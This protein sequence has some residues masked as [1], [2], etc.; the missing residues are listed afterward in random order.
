M[1]KLQ[2][3]PTDFNVNVDMCV[4]DIDGVQETFICWW[5]KHTNK[6]W[7]KFNETIVEREKDYLQIS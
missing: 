1:E 5:A 3:I 7:N 6:T 4:I 2:Q